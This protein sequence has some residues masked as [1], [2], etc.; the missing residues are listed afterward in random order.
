MAKVNFNV[1][2]KELGTDKPLESKGET[3]TLGLAAKQALSWSDEKDTGEE[4]FDNYQLAV[5]VS[6]GG[7]VDL[8]SEEI[9]RIKAAIGKYM[10]TVVVGQSWL[11]LEG[12]PVDIM[13][14]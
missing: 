5:K 7:E 1:V 9:S 8:K 3:F 13:K 10:S 4:K 12:E 14:K 11:L 2:L 6:G